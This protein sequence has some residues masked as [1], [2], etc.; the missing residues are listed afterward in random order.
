MPTLYR[1]LLT[2]VIFLWQDKNKYPFKY[3]M[4]IIALQKLYFLRNQSNNK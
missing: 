3:L 4:I 2:N 1:L